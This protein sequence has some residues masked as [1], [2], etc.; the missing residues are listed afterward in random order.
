M[1]RLD[2]RG[3]TGARQ[4]ASLSTPDYNSL[5]VSFRASARL[6]PLSKPTIHSPIY[7]YTFSHPSSPFRISTPTLARPHDARIYALLC[8]LESTTVILC[9]TRASGRE[10]ASFLTRALARTRTYVYRRDLI[11]RECATRVGF[12]SVAL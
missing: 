7:I 4:C 5:I 2:A 10:E 9:T 12:F 6:S 11:T 1:D 8:E 3:Q